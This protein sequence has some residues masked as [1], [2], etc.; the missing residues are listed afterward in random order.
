MKFCILLWV[1]SFL[2][3]SFCFAQAINK[4]NQQEKAFV[5]SI[6]DSLQVQVNLQYDGAGLP[7]YYYCHINTPVCE[8]GLCRLM[9]LDVYWDLLG[10]F[11]K[12]E[13]P[14]HSPLTKFDHHEFTREDHEK[15]YGILSDKASI[16]RDYPVE[17]LVDTQVKRKSEVVD[18]V[19]AA[20]RVGVKDAIVG[21]AV[22]STYVLWHIVN[23]SIASRIEAYTHPLFNEALLM[24][25]FDS[26]NLYYQFFALNHYHEDHVAAY[27]PRIIHLVTDGVSYIPY[28]AIEKLPAS[29]W[30][31]DPYQVSLLKHFRKADFEL[32]NAFLNKLK[33]VKLCSEALDLLVSG[34]GDIKEKQLIRALE[35][36]SNNQE[37]L[38]KSALSKISEFSNHQDKQ[39]SELVDLLLKCGEDKY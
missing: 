24:K 34:M 22:Y 20:T 15:L 7:D 5:D 1:G 21:G 30:A 16:L 13:L 27:I 9:V 33:D 37:R 39:I 17:D 14:P 10:N 2:F 32:Q 23:G 25:M 6:N 36:V 29:A 35:I 11:L 38:S 4:R 19:S 28:F 26:N 12:Y 18:A 3:L 31:N 8:Q